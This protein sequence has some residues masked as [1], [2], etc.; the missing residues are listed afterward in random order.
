MLH[1][2]RLCMSLRGMRWAAALVVVAACGGTAQLGDG[3]SAGGGGEGAGGNDT[4][5][6][7]GTGGNQG[8]MGGTAT[9]IGDA[10]PECETAAECE[11]V[12]SCCD[13]LGKPIDEGY[14]CPLQECFATQCSFYNPMPIEAECRVGRCVTNVDCDHT[15]VFCL[16]E[17]PAC[18]DGFTPTVVNGCW[19]GCLPATECAQV[20]HCGQ[21]APG[22]ACVAEATQVGPIYHCVDVPESCD[23]DTSCACLGESVCVGVFNLCSDAAAGHLECHCPTC[24]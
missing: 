11:L 13:C 22:Q 8:G 17:P 21:C 4:T 9:G 15:Q 1:A 12:N 16:S 3:P 19:G 24:G 23:G 7:T 20:G 10:E 5:T 6:T 18:P 14:D 2:N